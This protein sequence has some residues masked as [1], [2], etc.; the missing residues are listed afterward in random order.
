MNLVEILHKLSSLK[1]ERGRSKVLK[2]I[3]K[4]SDF[5]YVASGA[6]S[7]RCVCFNRYFSVNDPQYYGEGVPN[8]VIKKI[9]EAIQTHK[10]TPKD[11]A[12]ALEKFSKTC[13]KEEWKDFYRPFLEGNLYIPI[14]I[15]EFNKTCPSKYA[16]TPFV[17]VTLTPLE[18]ELTKPISEI[19]GINDGISNVIEPY[20]SAPRAYW[21]LGTER[22]VMFSEDGR[23][24]RHPVAD[25]IQ[26]ESISHVMLEVYVESEEILIVRDIYE[27]AP[28]ISGIPPWHGLLTR[29]DTAQ[30]LVRAINEKGYM[31]I[32]MNEYYLAKQQNVLNTTGNLILEQGYPGF[33]IRAYG[34]A[35]PEQYLI[36]PKK[37]AT[38]TCLDISHSHIV[39]EATVGRKKVRTKV[40]FGLNSQQRDQYFKDKDSFIGKRFDILCCAKSNEG[41]T[42]P[43]FQQWRN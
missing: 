42:I 38:L 33:V 26:F 41:I 29:L 23:R 24:I 8:G 22:T 13:T 17:G 5:W 36:L 15:K 12:L 1:T 18:N 4:D 32:E 6:L 10:L 3:P 11:E 14:S 21:F 37:K 19:S 31:G 16:S 27:S 30:S 40:Y 35:S 43:V 20:Y 25:K 34:Y 9:D 28:F 7:P 39:G 2:S